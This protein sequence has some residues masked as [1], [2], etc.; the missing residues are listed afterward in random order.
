MC[1]FGSWTYSM[2]EVSVAEDVS[3]SLWF[4]HYSDACPSV[5]LDHESEINVKYYAGVDEPYIDIIMSL[6]ITWR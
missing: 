6:E 3:G 2:F 1:R 4:G 5:V